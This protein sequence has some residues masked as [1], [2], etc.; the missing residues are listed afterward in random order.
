MEFLK[1]SCRIY[2]KFGFDSDDL[3]LAGKK[4]KIDENKEIQ[5]FAKL[6]HAQK[7]SEQMKEAQQCTPNEEM[8]AEIMNKAKALGPPQIKQ[9]GTLTFDYFIQTM[10][11]VIEYTIKHTQQALSDFEKQRREA[12]KE[13]NMEAYKEIV[14]KSSNFETMTTQII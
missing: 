1:V 11:I 9:D 7:Q 3:K 13:D 2:E 14:F 5:S 12:I 8:I 10:K 4:Y 6:A